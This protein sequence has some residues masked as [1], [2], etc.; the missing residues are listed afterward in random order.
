MKSQCLYEECSMQGHGLGLGRF[1]SPRANR[2]EQLWRDGQ[3]LLL[4][5]W[6]KWIPWERLPPRRMVWDMPETYN[7]LSQQLTGQ[8]LKA[9]KLDLTFPSF[10]ECCTN[11][12]TAWLKSSVLNSKAIVGS[13]ATIWSNCAAMRR[14]MDFK[15]QGRDMLGA[16][17]S[18]PRK[19][20]S[21]TKH[22]Q[23]SNTFSS[24]VG[25][26]FQFHAII[27]LQWT[28]FGWEPCQL[29]WCVG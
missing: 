1:T 2:K 5:A 4:E 6:R 21:F 24:Y 18:F 14:Y 23:D 16:R 11:T 8:W 27:W 29:E 19:D 22:K 9:H 12:D 20:W 28:S 3:S 7:T 10:Q 26:K 17:R 15:I 13:Q 25:Q